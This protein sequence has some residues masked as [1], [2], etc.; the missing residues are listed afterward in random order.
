MLVL[1]ELSKRQELGG[2]VI[3]YCSDGIV[4]VWW[5]WGSC[6]VEEAG[7]VLERGGENVFHVYSCCWAVGSCFVVL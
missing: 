2:V 3:R 6:G 5:C 7:L 1:N 4:V